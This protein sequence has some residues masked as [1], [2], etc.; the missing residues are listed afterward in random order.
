MRF[1][2]R[3]IHRRET[4]RFLAIAA[5]AFIVIVP[6]AGAHARLLRSNPAKNAGVTQPPAQID[7]WFNELLE[8]GFNTLEIFKSSELTSEKRTNLA[9]GKPAVD[10]DDHTHLSIKTELLPPG[11]YVAEWRVLS[12][13]GHSAPGRIVFRVTGPK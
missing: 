3:T 6:T 5:V 4:W 13:D 2:A 1:P 12:R 9:K 10:P 11:E 8:D 7:L